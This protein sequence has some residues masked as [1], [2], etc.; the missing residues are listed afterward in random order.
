M[1]RNIVAAV[2]ALAIVVVQP[3]VVGAGEIK[4][5]TARAIATVLAEIGSEFERETGHTLIISSDLPPAFVR[6]VNAGEPVDILIR[7]TGRGQAIDQV[8]HWAQGNS[9]YQGPG[10]GTRALARGA[11]HHLRNRL[12]WIH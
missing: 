11:E 2:M 1:S 6:R 8:P 12:A 7:G 9:D 10:H 3:G 5:W 4:V